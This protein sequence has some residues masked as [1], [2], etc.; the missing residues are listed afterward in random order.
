LN[1]II[2]T[3]TTHYFRIWRLWNFCLIYFFIK[4][5]LWICNCRKR[6]IFFMYFFKKSVTLFYALF[7]ALFKKNV[8]MIVEDSKRLLY[9]IQWLLEFLKSLF[10]QS[11]NFRITTINHNFNI[12]KHYKNLNLLFLVLSN[13]EW[14]HLLLGSYLLTYLVI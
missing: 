8:I 10:F 7:I 5:T 6:N 11:F 3:L 1:K 13:L 12:L 2:I 9:N 14:T 4:L